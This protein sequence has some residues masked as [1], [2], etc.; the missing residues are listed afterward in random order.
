M[1][2]KSLMVEGV[3]RF[4][5]VVHIDGFVEGVNVLAAGNEA[6]KSTLFRAIRT[7]LFSRHDSKVQEIKDLGSDDSQLPATVQLTFAHN[8][9]TYVIK[10]CFLRS[11]S[12]TLTED[13]REIARGKQADEAVWGLLGLSPG[14]GRTLDDGAFGV[15]W[16]GQG[17]SFRIPAPGA[18]ASSVLN[19]AIESEVGALIGGERARQAVEDI[20]TELR[21]YLTDTNRPKSDGPLHRAVQE[22]EH[23]QAAETVA[24]GK[25]TALEQQFTN[26]L[27]LRQRHQELTDPA[28]TD[29][30]AKELVEARGSL[31][32]ARSAAQEIRRFEAEESSARR[33]LEGASQ[34]LK[35][36]RDLTGRIDA[37]RQSE[38]AQTRGLPEQ[39]AREQEA[40]AA[41][42]RTQEQIADTEKQAQTLSANEQQLEK[43]SSAAIRAIRKDDLARQL[44]A[45]ERAAKELLQIDAQLAQI[46]IN[47]KHIE[48]LDELERQ[49]AT[50]DAQLSATAAHLSVEVMAAGAGQVRIG[51][52]RPKGTYSAPVVAPT[53]VTVG[54]LA[55]ITVTPAPNPRHEKRQSVDAERSALLESIGVATSAEARALLSKRR[56]LEASRKAVLTELKSLKVTGDPASVIA[57]TKSDLAETDAA[58]SAALTDTKRQSL[59]SSKEIEEEKLELS[60]KRA[61]LDARRASLE[62][63]REQQQEALEGAV[64]SRSGTES[65]LELIRKSIED[66]IAL[67]PD[68]ERAPRD[69]SLVADV[70]T[71]E[72]AQQTA[73]TVLSAK[74]QTTPDAAEIERREVRG[75]RL[76]QALENRKNDLIQLEREIGRLTG[77]I[78]TAGGDGVGETLAAAQEQRALAERERSRIQ[79]RAATL[80]LLRDTVSSCLTEGRERYYE[81]VRKHLRP[82]LHDLFPGA[83][84]ELGDGFAITGIKRDRAESFTRLSD[85]T[86][87][88]IAVLVR[89]A[90]ASMLAERGQTVPVI[91][92]DALVY[93]DDDRIKLMFDALSRAGKHQQ[94]I[95]LTCRLRTFAPLGG[96]ALRVQVPSEIS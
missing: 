9:H 83:E 17:A 16:V 46:N 5:S 14:S 62:E 33:A 96:H 41:L 22:V 66:D 25:L 61:P 87:E 10:K 72:T 8:G 13:G 95:V 20:N 90:M 31:A 48:D 52:T 57:K 23:W 28:A 18:A 74:R 86:Q 64:A 79:E 68:S 78:Q 6:G 21:R 42:L 49:I 3:G 67:C 7:C 26:L 59:P 94:V 12:A 75:Q 77:Q 24:Q 47:P 34:R 50:F 63:T 60:Q 55:V 69:A 80:Q 27:Q 76:E 85:G 88:Q 89:L 35:Q 11:P 15:L 54:E 56:D 36:L 84:L 32:D 2:I 81:P 93:C 39:Q 44:T 45:L 43:L 58:I 73:A 30:L 19:S 51:T 82:F 71:A 29:Q 38:V 1:F 65:K 92:D 4:A 70:T 53:K 37:S 40:R 91:L